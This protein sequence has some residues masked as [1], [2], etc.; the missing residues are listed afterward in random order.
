MTIETSRNGTNCYSSNGANDFPVLQAANA[1][2]PAMI[3]TA[4]QTY[5]SI[6]QYAANFLALKLLGAN[7]NPKALLAPSTGLQAPTTPLKQTQAPSLQE[8]MNDALSKKQG[9]TVVRGKNEFSELETWGAALRSGR[10]TQISESCKLHSIDLLSETNKEGQNGPV[11]IATVYDDEF[12][13]RFKVPIT[14]L[15]LNNTRTDSLLR[16]KVSSIQSAVDQHKQLIQAAFVDD[17]QKQVILCPSNPNLAR[18][19]G[20]AH[21]A[22]EPHAPAKPIELNQEIQPHYRPSQEGGESAYKPESKQMHCG[23]QAIEAFCQAP[24]LDTTQMANVY[25]KQAEY[26]CVKGFQKEPE[27]MRGLYHPKLLRAFQSG[28]NCTI[29]RDEFFPED[30]ETFPNVNDLD[31]AKLEEGMED[32]WKKLFNMTHPDLSYMDNRDIY[33]R[34]R[35]LHVSPSQWISCLRGMEMETLISTMNELLASK[36]PGTGWDHLPSRVEG[37][38]INTLSDSADQQRYELARRIREAQAVYKALGQDFPMV[39]LRGQGGAGGSNHYFAVTQNKNGLW[40]NLNSDGA[41]KSG[42]HHCR[43]FSEDDPD[44]LAQ[45]LKDESVTHVVCPVLF[46]QQK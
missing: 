23:W 16:G 13:V 26:V 8:C 5:A 7:T 3:R 6:L 18:M 31:P 41:R 11:W 40:L 33:N 34:T 19:A 4:V 28:Q 30:W 44:E 29:S 36:T 25:A 21:F 22:Q 17:K 43:K 45:A 2:L 42:I 1:L 20:S 39:L 32:E 9:F 35:T 46:E 15:V 24:V 14:E 37:Y 10:S 12:G 38:E 27:D